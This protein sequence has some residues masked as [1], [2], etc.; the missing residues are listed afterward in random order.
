MK[1]N[2]Q[3]IYSSVSIDEV[4]KEIIGRCAADLNLPSLFHMWQSYPDMLSMPQIMMLRDNDYIQFDVVTGWSESV[5]FV[6][7]ES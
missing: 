4:L 7:H 3:R 1:P 5:A 6:V 2:L